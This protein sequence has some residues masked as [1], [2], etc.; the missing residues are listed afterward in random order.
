MGRK[1]LLLSICMFVVF[2]LPGCRENLEDHSALSLQ[3]D[4]FWEERYSTCKMTDQGKTYAVA[5]VN[6]KKDMGEKDMFKILDYYRLNLVEGS[7]FDV[8]EE[9]AVVYAV[10]YKGDTDE[11]I[12]KFK[13]VNGESVN[14]AE[15][16]QYYF[17]APNMH[18]QYDEEE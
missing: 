10:F 12:G 11:E 15:E 6:V 16:E 9:E 1:V 14:I 17:P 7:G 18:N 5:S 8:K 4:G 3:E 13:Y 2:F